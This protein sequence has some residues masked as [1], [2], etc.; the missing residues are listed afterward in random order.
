MR[1]AF[2]AVCLA[3]SALAQQT[4]PLDSL[5]PTEIK[6]A[7]EILRASGK[8]TSGSEFPVLCLNE[9]PK[10]AVLAGT[11]TRREA[12]AIVFER[13]TS[14]TAEAIVDLASRSVRSWKAVLGVQPGFM[15]E[16]YQALLQAVRGNS[17]WQAAVRKRG[18]T[19]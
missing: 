16:D 13:K 14:R 12:F 3:G 7:V 19:D 9:P 2:V 11:G 18:I 17:E 6:T 4:H 8:V 1:A 10:A 5:T 15:G